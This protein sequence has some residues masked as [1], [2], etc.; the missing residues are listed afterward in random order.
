[1]SAL[2]EGLTILYVLCYNSCKISDSCYTSFFSC[3][4][5][6][7]DSPRPF[8]SFYHGNLHLGTFFISL[9]IRPH[10]VLAYI[11]QYHS[12]LNYWYVFLSLVLRLSMQ[13]EIGFLIIVHHLASTTA[14]DN[15]PY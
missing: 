2:K 6:S 3:F 1:M 9:H 4:P 13:T 14:S 7:L 11:V 5:G 15:P 10:I 12:P 8:S